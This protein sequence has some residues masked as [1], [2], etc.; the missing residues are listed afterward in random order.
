MHK[1]MAFV[2]KKEWNA[3]IFA[4]V[5]TYENFAQSQLKFAPLHE[6]DI[7]SSDVQWVFLSVI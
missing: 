5:Y 6:G 4:F 7:R 2:R 1:N 3:S